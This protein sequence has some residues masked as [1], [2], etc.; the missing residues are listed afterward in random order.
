MIRF[1]FKKYL[2][3]SRRFES[4]S[5]KQQFKA[6]PPGLPKLRKTIIFKE[7]NNVDQTVEKKL[8]LGKLHIIQYTAANGNVNLY[9]LYKIYQ[10]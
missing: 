5:V 8:K 7:E 6:I 4:A 10:K 9:I 3:A 2:W 1:R